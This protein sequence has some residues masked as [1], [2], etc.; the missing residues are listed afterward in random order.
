MHEAE[1]VGPRYLAGGVRF[2]ALNAIDLRLYRCGIAIVPDRSD[3]RVAGG[4]VALWNR[5]G[6]PVRLKL[7]NGGP[8]VAPLASA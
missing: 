2:Y 8:F 3:E 4:L 7:D 5:L 6:L 1:L